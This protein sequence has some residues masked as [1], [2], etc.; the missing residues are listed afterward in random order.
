MRACIPLEI[1]P[2][3]RLGIE[4]GRLF[5]QPN[6]VEPVLPSGE[7]LLAS[8]AGLCRAIIEHQVD[9]PLH[10]LLMRLQQVQ[11]AHEPRCVWCGAHELDP[12]APQDRD[13]ARTP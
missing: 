4:L 11:I 13:A 5:G 12:P 1:A 6:D 2:L 3:A 7:R 8:F 9:L 10:R